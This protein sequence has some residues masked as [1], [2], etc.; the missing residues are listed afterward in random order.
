MAQGVYAPHS[1]FRNALNF[2][3]GDRLLCLVSSSVG[4]GPANIVFAGPLPAA[5]APLEVSP[6][7]LRWG[8]ACFPFSGVPAYR[9]SLD[10]NVPRR[11]G[12]EANLGALLK[13]LPA[14]APRRSLSF[15]LGGK[16]CR[17]TVFDRQSREWIGAACSE[18]FDNDLA[19]G[20]RLIRGAGPGLTPSGD[21]LLCGALAALDA[22]SRLS[23]RDLTGR[24]DEV[25][26][27]AVGGNP[28]SNAFLGFA[29]RGLYGER[30]KALAAAILCGEPAEVEREAGRALLF[31][32]TS[33]ADWLTGFGLAMHRWRDLWS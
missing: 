1:A 25:Y 24:R 19:A 33:G 29:R 27:N 15:L 28:F 10:G 3:D 9:S 2:L 8:G 17:G 23:G 13:W 18:L 32:A 30:F 6:E 31:G 5:D 4:A 26:R 12:V 22:A 20:V 11:E 7:G 16:P 14:N 21:D